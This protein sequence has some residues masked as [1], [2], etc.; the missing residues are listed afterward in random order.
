MEYSEHPWTT[1]LAEVQNERRDF[2]VFVASFQS[3]SP[4]VLTASSIAGTDLLNVSHCSTV[5]LIPAFKQQEDVSCE[6]FARI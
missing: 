4:S 5:I 1:L 3:D 2:K 6:T